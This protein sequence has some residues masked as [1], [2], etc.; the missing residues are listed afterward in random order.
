LQKD[1]EVAGYM[2]FHIGC[3]IGCSEILIIHQIYAQKLV[4]EMF[5]FWARILS[6]YFL[7]QPVA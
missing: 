7:R 2:V 6:N 5:T 3:R 1:W 4:F